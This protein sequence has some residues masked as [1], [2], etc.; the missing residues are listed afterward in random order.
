M[1]RSA[2]VGVPSSHPVEPETKLTEIGA[3]GR[4]IILSWTNV[5]GGCPIDEGALDSC[6]VEAC[7]AG[8]CDVEW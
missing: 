6:A 5:V 4:P 2:H 1:A 7:T 8:R 3:S